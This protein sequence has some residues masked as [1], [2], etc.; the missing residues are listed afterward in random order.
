VSF[1]DHS[2]KFRSLLG[3]GTSDDRALV[4][5]ASKESQAAEAVTGVSL[6]PVYEAVA[7]FRWSGRLFSPGTRFYSLGNSSYNRF[8]FVA[9]RIAQG[10]IYY[11]PIR[12]LAVLA[13]TELPNPLGGYP[14]SS[15]VS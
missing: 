14:E 2:G 7:G 1:F 5:H 4:R 12:V 13:P 3:P 8:F 15:G 9:L 11:L 6:N 10:S